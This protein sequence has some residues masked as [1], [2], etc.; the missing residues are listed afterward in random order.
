[1]SLT[2]TNET[3]VI[4]AVWFLALLFWVLVNALCWPY[5]INSW[6][7]YLGRDAAVVWWQGALIGFV[8]VVNKFAIGAA[9]L[10]FILMMIL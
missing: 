2:K 9:I 3:S 7:E 5:T 4:A 1:M 8:P 6:L 10:T